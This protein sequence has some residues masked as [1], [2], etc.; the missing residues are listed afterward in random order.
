[1]VEVALTKVEVVAKKLVVVALPNTALFAVK[2]IKLPFKVLKLVVKKFVVVLFVE[3][4]L[5]VTRLVAVALV[6]LR[7]VIVPDAAVRSAIVA[8]AIVVV[9]S[10]DVPVTTKVLV[11]VASVTVSPSMIAVTAWKNEEKRLVEDAKSTVPLVA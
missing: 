2:S 10:V 11:V 4:L 7:S 1:M 3:E 5:K 8:F 6:A 9:A